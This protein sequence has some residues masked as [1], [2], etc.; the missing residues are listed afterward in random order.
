MKTDNYS[1]H[2]SKNPLKQFFINNFF[3]TIH[4]LLHDKEIKSVLDVGCGEG[5]TLKRL[6]QKAIGN[7]FTG[8][9]SSKE[10]IELGQKENPDLDLE[11]GDIYNLKFKDKSYDLVLC[12]EVFEHLDS[13]KK[14]L[15]ELKRISKKFILL[16][17]PNE[18]WFY[19]FNYTQWGKDIGHINSWSK[20][21]FVK[22]IKSQSLKV[23]SAKTPFPWTVLLCKT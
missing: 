4:E 23:V 9:D 21:K 14:A 1:K 18:P 19:L 10:A 20:N 3:K 7:K 12:T 2:T 5:F 11:I 16:S 13:P 15:E 8:I 22:F 6:K 17:V